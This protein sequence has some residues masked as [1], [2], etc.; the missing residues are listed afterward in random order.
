MAC[1]GAR[2]GTQ[3]QPCAHRRD[4]GWAWTPGAAAGSS[5][6]GTARRRAGPARPTWAGWRTAARGARP[7][8]AP[9]AAGWVRGP[10]RGHLVAARACAF[11]APGCAGRCPA[12]PAA[13]CIML[14]LGCPASQVWHFYATA[15]RLSGGAAGGNSKSLRGH[16]P[17]PQGHFDGTYACVLLRRLVLRGEAPRPAPGRGAPG[18][19]DAPVDPR[20]ASF[21]AAHEGGARE[22][23]APGGRPGEQA[24]GASGGVGEGAVAMAFERFGRSLG[25]VAAR[26][27]PPGEAAPAS[28]GAAA[29]QAVQSRSDEAGVGAAAGGPEAGG[30]ATAGGRAWPPAGPAA[31]P[32][33]WSAPAAEAASA[34]AL[35]AEP[36]G[37][38]GPLPQASLDRPA[39]R[40]AGGDPAEA[41]GAAPPG[42]Q[43]AAPPAEL[44]PPP[45]S[46][47]SGADTLAGSAAAGAAADAPPAAP[48][49]EVLHAAGRAS[50]LPALVA[51]A[52]AGCKGVFLGRGG[53]RGV[54]IQQMFMAGFV[55]A[56]LPGRPAHLVGAVPHAHHDLARGRR[57]WCAPA[58]P[59]RRPMR[60]PAARSSWRVVCH[61]GLQRPV[62]ARV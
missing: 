13:S 30:A 25:A 22:A 60:W 5:R 3:K 37:S 21:I 31:D 59:R 20:V 24:G 4:S 41:A 53:M 23:I 34:G 36:A 33:A 54:G 2:E 56:H 7:P 55:V 9:M 50:D 8:R 51:A 32:A 17:L 12:A 11:A 62:V 40:G 48:L 46:P 10:H 19:A 58:R 15:S 42:R 29:V 18:P 38:G 45:G 16:D 44:Q 26:S 1:L 39:A 52:V 47:A 28:T 35:G 6:R 27:D 14:S 61:A 43:A 57:R 49:A